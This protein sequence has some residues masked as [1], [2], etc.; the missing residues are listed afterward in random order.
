VTEAARLHQLIA[1]P[2]AKLHRRSSVPVWVGSL[3]VALVVLALFSASIM[4]LVAAPGTG[5]A[6]ESWAMRASVFCIISAG[7]T[8]GVV[9][10]TI[11]FVN[12]MGQRLRRLLY[13]DDAESA[14]PEEAASS[15]PVYGLDGKEVGSGRTEGSDSASASHAAATA[16]PEA[17]AGAGEDSRGAD[18]DG[19][20]AGLQ[21]RR[22]AASRTGADGIT[23][24]P[25]GRRSATLSAR[26]SKPFL[27]VP[28]QL[29]WVSLLLFTAAGLFFGVVFAATTDSDKGLAE[30]QE[31]TLSVGGSIG[32]I[33]GF[34]SLFVHMTAG[35]GADGKT[36]AQRAADA[37]ITAR[38]EQAARR[39][40]AADDAASKMS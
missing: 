11:H 4:S 3:P 25:G 23:S 16:G 40:N 39:L 15:S 7:F 35:V 18:L 24:R 30:R 1:D 9:I 28:V 37:S 22:G 17:D 20:A 34:W 19:A 29:M 6:K 26:A 32:A 31:L 27:A 33:I 2:M 8:T 36:D 5:I 13:G 12:G 14:A 10:F 38:H 21:A